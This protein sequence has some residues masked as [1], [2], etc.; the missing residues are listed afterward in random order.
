[1]IVR[2]QDLQGALKRLEAAT[3]YAIDTETTGLRAYQGDHAFSLIIA[4]D[5]ESFYF[6]FK[7]YDGLAD[8]WVLPLDETLYTLRPIFEKESATFY[9]Q[10][11][12][13]D[14]AIL[15]REYVTIK[16][17]IH[18][19][20]VVGRLIYNRHHDYSLDA[21][22]KR[23]GLEK[24]DIVEK[25][26]A[27]HKLYTWINS[28]G[29]AKRSKQPH[30]DQMP[31]PIIS[32][33]GEQDGRVTLL[34]GQDQK[35]R[36]VE[37]T[38]VLASNKIL[39]LVNTESQL[40][41]TCF[42]MEKIGIRIDRNY[43]QKAF[44]FENKRALAAADKFSELSGSEFI[45]SNK[46]LAEA[47][48]K[49]GEKY[50]TSDKG[51]PSFTEEVLAGFTTPLALHLRE[52]RDATKR[53]NTYF[54][55][56][57]HFADGLHRVHAN[58]RQC[59][60]DTGRFS[61]SDPSLQNC[62]KDDAGA[63]HVRRAFIPTRGFFFAMLDYEQIEFRVMLDYAGELGVISKIINEGLDVHTATAKTMGVTRDKAKTLNFLL[64][65]GGGAQKL[66]DSLGMTLLEAKKLKSLYFE[67]LP[68]VSEFLRGITERANTRGFIF[69]WAGRVSYFPLVMNPKNNRLDRFAYRAGNHC[70]QG[71]CADIIKVAM[72]RIDAYLAN[73]RSRMVL[74]V[75]DEL[76]FEVAFGEEYIMPFLKKIMEEAYPHEHL[77]M[78]VDIE[79]SLK[80]WADKEE[81]SLE[82][83]N[84][85]RSVALVG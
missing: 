9:L 33:Y 76:I 61:I 20:E 82:A 25:H 74:T 66:A 64:I 37:E 30:Y 83:Y 63:Y 6:N 18:D 19:T 10:N 3:E 4:I 44:E 16:G 77:P 84:K 57:L 41:K 73:K 69:N 45:D 51:N 34:L 46:P 13:F 85:A 32:S 12:K 21:Q 5:S 75:H 24:S 23:I 39:D 50:P 27:K 22:C 80:S 60:A 38:D 52:F 62:S 15:S 8:D 70:I 58:I 68:K 7:K 36:L 29:K 79:F 14:M 65:Y 11:A 72:N 17:E 81:W 1:M 59:G 78:A 47:F 2:R 28:P 40:V 55:N 53:A 67:S 26:I 49:A 56:F 42:A 31:F 35:R 54:S 71:A 43:C 48:T